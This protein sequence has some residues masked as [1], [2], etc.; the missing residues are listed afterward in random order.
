MLGL[1][2]MRKAESPWRDVQL[3]QAVNYAIDRENLIRYAAKGNG[4]LVPALLPVRAFGH[5][6]TL[7]PY[8][9]APAKAQHLLREA[10]YVDGLAITLIATAA[11]EVQATVVSKM[12]EQIGFT[13]QRQILDDAA[14]LKAVNL[15]WVSALDAKTIPWSCQ[16]GTH[17]ILP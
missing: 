10:G 11:L 9:F 16:R 1:L 3:R 4:V 15:Y 8:A 12:L 17:G 6:P 5:D 2:N 14:F 7:A 13:V